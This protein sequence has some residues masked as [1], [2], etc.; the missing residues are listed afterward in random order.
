LL[1]VVLR[2][3]QVIPS[4]APILLNAWDDAFE[5]EMRVLERYGV[6]NGFGT[7]RA[8]SVSMFGKLAF[9]SLHT[10]EITLITPSIIG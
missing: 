3:L 9:R 2:K 1:L 4:A 8:C 10:A 6:L 7:P 5:K